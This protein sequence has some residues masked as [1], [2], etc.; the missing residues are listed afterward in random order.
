[1]KLG[2]YIKKLSLEEDPRIGAL[3]GRLKDGGANVYELRNASGV[4]PGTEMVLSFGGDGTFLSCARIVSEAGVPI[5]GVNFG[6][7]GFLSE[8]NHDI[9]GPL[10]SGAYSV[11]ERVMLKVDVKGW[12]PEDFWPYALNEACLHRSG[13]GMLGL[14]ASVNGEEL[15][16]YW[17]DGLLVATS[18]GSTAYSL[19]VG[20]PIC[21]PDADVLILSPVAPHNLNLRPL[22]VP[23]GSTIVMGTRKREEEAFLTL[24]NRS[25]IIPQ[26]MSVAIS[27]APFRLKRVSIGKSNF[28]DALRSRLFWGQDVRNIPQ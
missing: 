13:P 3:L 2:Y 5:L 23:G 7:M 21:L 8:T 22:V 15:P 4:Q 11:E 19:S 14:E 12:V 18:S 24:D 26:G 28:I 17:A 25:Y 27:E 6:R 10:L 20:G 9:V 16:T 1:M